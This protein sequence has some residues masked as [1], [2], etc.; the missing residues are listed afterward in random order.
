[1]QNKKIFAKIFLVSLVFLAFSLPVLALEVTYPPVPFGP[2]I[3]ADTDLAGYVLYFFGFAV[4]IAGTIGVISIVYSG[5]L[6]L[7][8]AGNPSK[9]SEA[10]ERIWGSILG[11]ILLMF[12]VVLLRTINPDLVKPV[13]SSFNKQA[14]VYFEGSQGKLK[15]AA[16]AIADTSDIVEFE[17]EYTDIVYVCTQNQS[18]T[19][20]T[21][22]V[23]L[24]DQKNFTPSSNA[25]TVAL[26]CGGTG[27]VSISSIP[28]S[29]V[30]SSGPS[31]GGVNAVASFN[32]EYEDAGIYYYLKEGCDGLASNIQKGKGKI[33]LFGNE[34]IEN[35]DDETV[36]SLRIVSGTDNKWRYGVILNKNS[37]GS[38]ECSAP[39]INSSPGSVC[40]D[41]I[42]ND[43]DG[44]PFAP[45]YAHVINQYPEATATA[46]DVKL[47]SNNYFVKLTDDQ[48]QL[49]YSI[50]PGY[51]GNFGYNGTPDEFMR[52]QCNP[53]DDPTCPPTGGG[54]GKSFTFGAPPY[55][56]TPI[57]PYQTCLNNVK[58]S[59]NFYTIIY[60]KNDIDSN[61]N[62]VID[63][64]EYSDRACRVF[65]NG[66]GGLNDDNLLKGE[67]K[68]Y[69]LD[70]IPY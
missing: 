44:K 55:E 5:F 62:G 61:Q 31:S 21:L 26:P 70:I 25:K 1:M 68:P 15:Q 35:M 34:S 12:S 59:G 65:N 38:G 58:T 24:Y 14:G 49:Q 6:I 4:M 8:S 36:K 23:N 33:P 66:V 28:S 11:I 3:T 63:T 39:I 2:K 50:F 69:R 7:V 60:V 54:L 13:S 32:W 47:Y 46:T 37:D 42:P 29:S 51:S 9:I 10:K 20:K 30:S 43:M 57:D 18:N 48:I 53:S 67:R 17:Q 56:C 16:Q 45:R 22:L 41:V 40:I 52:P 64:T 19:S 27:R